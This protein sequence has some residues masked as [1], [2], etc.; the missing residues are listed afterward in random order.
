MKKTLL[1]LAGAGITLMH[2][3]SP[4][5]TEWMMNTNGDQ[6]VYQYYQSMPSSNLQT[7]NMTDSTDIEKVCYSNTHVYL[8]SDGLANYQMGPFAGNPNQPAARN[9]IFKLTRN[10]AQETGT[11]QYT[12]GTIGVTVN[13]C[14][15]YGPSDARSYQSSSNANVSNGDG[16]WWSDAWVSEGSTMDATGNGHPDQNGNYHYHANP[17]TLYT[18]PS[19][20]HSPIIGYALDGFPIYGPYGYTSAMSSSSGVTRMTSSYQLRNITTRT[21]LPDGTT[22]TPAGPV[23]SS[24]FPLG[25]YMQD[26]EYISGS[27]T[28]D[29][30]NGRFCVTPE[31]PSGIYAYFIATDASG[32]PDFP[33]VTTGYF[34]GV[35]SQTDM[36]QAGSSTMPS[37]GLTCYTGATVGLVDIMT[38]KIASVFP[39]P[40]SNE[41]HVKLD[42]STNFDVKIL[43][44]TGQIVKQVELQN[45]ESVIDI[46]DL[47]SGVYFIHIKSETDAKQVIRF[48]KE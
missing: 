37:T 29:E 8:R 41:V 31:Y 33:Y 10:P 30:Y 28:L 9:Y 12:I 24:S 21:V 19:T 44:I 1:L 18:D 46:N 5:I 45:G 7:V 35:I 36:M 34:Y 20:T 23:V 26:Y 27:G 16:N 38:G 43:T 17:K 11:K 3:Q 22:S 32:N 6:A 40:A 47:S 13:G 2:A 42:G 48:I 15:I 4:V 14:K 25:T 39:N